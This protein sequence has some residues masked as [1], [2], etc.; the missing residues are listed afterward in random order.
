MRRQPQT[1]YASQALKHEVI[2]RR[3]GETALTRSHSPLNIYSSSEEGF[4]VV[5]L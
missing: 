3:V 2:F 1:E 5:F 4:T